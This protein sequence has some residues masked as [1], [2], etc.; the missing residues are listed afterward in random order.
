MS[1]SCFSPGIINLLSN[2]I[3]TTS[4]L[5]IQFTTWLEEYAE[6]MG[7]EIYRMKLSKKM[8]NRTFADIVGF[9]YKKNQSIVFALEIKTGGRT[10]IRL[11]PSDFVVNNIEKNSIHVYLICQDKKTADEIETLDMDKAEITQYLNEQALAGKKRKG[12]EDEEDEDDD[13]DGGKEAKHGG[14]KH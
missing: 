8:D 9:V 6:G 13:E 2:L 1:K 7:N 12:D 14:H 10:I 11:N 3:T 5:N 4:E